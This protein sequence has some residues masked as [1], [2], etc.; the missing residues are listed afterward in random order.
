MSLAVRHIQSS[1]IVSRIHQP[2][3]AFRPLAVL[4][5]SFDRRRFRRVESDL[6]SRFRCGGDWFD[7]H[8]ENVSAGGAAVRCE[9]KP[10]PFSRVLFQIR[11]VGLVRA[12]V[13]D[14]RSDGFRVK[15]AEEDLDQ[16]AMVEALTLMANRRL[17]F[18]HH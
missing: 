3:Q 12:L 7:A 5:E 14:W 1:D 18:S 2:K 17:L 4:D 16:E 9:S 11:G 15:F 10:S 13:M 8:V 6:P